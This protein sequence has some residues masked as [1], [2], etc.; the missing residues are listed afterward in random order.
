M[1][2]AALSSL[3]CGGVLYLRAESGNQT[4]PALVGL[5]TGAAVLAGMASRSRAQATRAA[6]EAAGSAEKA[7]RAEARTAVLAERTRNARD[8]HDVLAH[9]LAG[10]NMQLELV[11]A[12]RQDPRPGP[13][14]SRTPRP[15]GGPDLSRLVRSAVRPT[16]TAPPPVPSRAACVE[17]R[18]DSAPVDTF[19]RER[20]DELM[21]RTPFGVTR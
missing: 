11:D 1:A 9:S 6:I 3:L 14:R 18:A 12:L 15:H 21:D 2:V 17:G 13:G 8:I 19:G 5:A 20:E 7:A 4:V 16:R 10:I